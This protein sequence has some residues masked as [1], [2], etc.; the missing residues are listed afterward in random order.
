[1]LGEQGENFPFELQ[2]VHLQPG[3]TKAHRGLENVDDDAQSDDRAKGV[4]NTFV[5]EVEVLVRRCQ[6]RGMHSDQKSVRD[7]SET[8]GTGRRRYMLRGP[9]LLQVEQQRI[10]TFLIEWSDVASNGRFTNFQGK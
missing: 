5:L 6:S 9:L 4:P 2:P 8:L 7:T 10:W 3:P 1:M